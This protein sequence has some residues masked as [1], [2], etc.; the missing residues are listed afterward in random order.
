MQSNVSVK[1]GMI[2]Y[3]KSQPTITGLLLASGTEIRERQWQGEDFIF[4]AIRVSLDFMPSVNGC[5]PDGADF[6]IE[7]FSEKPSSLEADTIAGA[8]SALLHKRPFS[9]TITVPP[10]P[11]DTLKFPVVIVTKV[12]KAERSIYGWLSRVNLKTQVV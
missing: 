7:V 5:G 9:V 2:A 10:S 11:P 1:A 8:L 6:L 12:D 3:L 4:P